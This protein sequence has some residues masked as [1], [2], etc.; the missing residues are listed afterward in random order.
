MLLLELPQHPARA[1]APCRWAASPGAP[2]APGA[3]PGPL[4]LGCFSWSS[5]STRRVPRHLLPPYFLQEYLKSLSIV[6]TSSGA[7]FNSSLTL[8]TAGTGLIVISSLWW[9][10]MR[11]LVRS[12]SLVLFQ[13]LSMHR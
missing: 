13:G 3:C 4:P 11:A 7:L 9:L 10:D 8:Q 1:Q 12:I 6:D 5:P 2:P